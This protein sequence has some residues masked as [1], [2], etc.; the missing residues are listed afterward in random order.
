MSDEDKDIEIRPFRGGGFPLEPKIDFTGFD[1]VTQELKVSDDGSISIYDDEKTNFAVENNVNSGFSVF[2]KSGIRRISNN[3]NKSVEISPSSNQGLTSSSFDSVVFPITVTSDKIDIDFSNGPDLYNVYITTETS[4]FNSFNYTPGSSKLIRVTSD[5]LARPLTFP[6]SWKFLTIKPTSIRPGTV[7][8][9][10]LSCFGSQESDCVASWQVSE[11]N[12]DGPIVTDGLIVNLDARDK[13]SQPTEEKIW[14][15][16]YNRDASAL[17]LNGPSYVPEEYGYIEFDGS[18]DYADITPFPATNYMTFA[19]WFN[20]TEPT[21]TR[22]TV[23]LNTTSNGGGASLTFRTNDGRMS[24][25]WRDAAW[26]SGGYPFITAPQIVNDGVWH[27]VAAVYDQ[28]GPKI[29][30]D[31]ELAVQ[32]VRNSTLYSSGSQFFRIA[33][34]GNQT[35]I[36]RTKTK[37]SVVQVYNRGLS[38]SEVNQ[39]YLAFKNRYDAPIGI[40]F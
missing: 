6:S 14:Y 27:Y 26:S 21:N 24:F 28:Y 36:Y 3:Q 29:Y 11:V 35:S 30:V 7:C 18:V 34:L 12:P 33:G 31:G 8:L 23:D 10:S 1:N 20:T 25:T 15:N 22:P 37:I 32:G 2:D 38:E 19:T 4:F 40:G 39:N 9:L 13:N 16:V 5:N 17:L